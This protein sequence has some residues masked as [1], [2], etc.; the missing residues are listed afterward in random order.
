MSE[1]ILK[2]TINPHKDNYAGYSII[3][4]IAEMKLL[5]VSPQPLLEIAA[6]DIVNRFGAD[7]HIYVEMMLNQVTEAQDFGGIFLWTA[8]Q[9]LLNIASS[10]T[11]TTI[12]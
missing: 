5:G 1:V 3:E 4:L 12:H 7:G 9:K 10:P 11:C 2:N 6:K 8:L